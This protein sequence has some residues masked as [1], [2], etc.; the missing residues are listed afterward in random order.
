MLR[1]P[2]KPAQR[3]PA[4][5]KSG[6]QR[7]GSESAEDPLSAAFNEASSAQREQRVE[8][9]GSV[10]NPQTRTEIPI[11]QQMPPLKTNNAVAR[12]EDDLKLMVQS[13]REAA[14]RV[15][16]NNTMSAKAS[17]VYDNLV[18]FS[19]SS[20]RIIIDLSGKFYTIVSHLKE[21]NAELEALNVQLSNTPL[22]SQMNKVEEKIQRNMAS[23]RKEFESSVRQVSE[24][25]GPDITSLINQSISNMNHVI[26]QSQSNV[27]GPYVKK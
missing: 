19:N 15:T 2:R 17:D 1:K 6:T 24:Y 3:K 20:M 26:N 16:A 7:G 13:V 10:Y 9:R 21:M 22:A 23:L 8:N 12:L 27:G 14:K 11:R 5:K 4:R 25:A 18:D